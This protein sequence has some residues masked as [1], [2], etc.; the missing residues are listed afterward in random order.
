MYETERSDGAGM[1]AERPQISGQTRLYRALDLDPRVLDYIVSL[2]PHEFVRLRNPLLRR[3]MSPRITLSRVANMAGIPVHELVERVAELGGGV[4][5]HAAAEP[6][7]PESPQA[8]P[9]WVEKRTRAPYASW[10]CSRTTMRSMP[11]R[12]RR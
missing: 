8:E 7:L 12:C 10:I 11:T 6:E 5:E 9:D 1:P 2:A 3:L 4:A